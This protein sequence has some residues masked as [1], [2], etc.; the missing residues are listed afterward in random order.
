M[1]YFISKDQYKT[2]EFKIRFGDTEQKKIPC[3]IIATQGNK[4][5]V[6]YQTNTGTS[7]K[8]IDKEQIVNEQTKN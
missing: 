3:T 1:T 6:E 5:L 7:M 2:T 8:W 4:T